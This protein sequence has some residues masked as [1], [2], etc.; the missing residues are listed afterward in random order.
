[1]SRRQHGLSL[2]ELLVVLAVVGA[3][4][5]ALTLALGGRPERLLE[6]AARRT[7]ALLDLACERAVLTGLDIGWRFESEGLRFGFM[8][9]EGWQEIGDDAGDELRPRAWDAGLQF[10]LRRD[11][12]AVDP[13]A[14]PLQPQLLCLASGELTPFVL[15][16]SHAGTGQRWLLEGEA[17]GNLRLEHVDPAKN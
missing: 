11:D 6:N 10:S 13:D 16:L 8:R 7:T 17:D 14:D 2:I 5:G 15:E 1:M 9:V 3:M 4:L 12:L